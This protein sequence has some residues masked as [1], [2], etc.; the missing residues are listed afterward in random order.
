MADFD[1]IIDDSNIRVTE[2]YFRR[3]NGQKWRGIRDALYDTGA[4]SAKW[5]RRLVETG[6]RSGRLYVLS[7]RIRF[8]AQ[9]RLH[10]ASAPFEPPARM[11]G[12]LAKGVQYAVRQV[13]ELEV[14]VRLDDRSLPN[15]PKMLE[16]GTRKMKARPFVRPTSLE[17]AHRMSINLAHYGQIEAKRVKR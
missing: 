10:R 11:T 15:Y 7:G 13:H 3:L 5:M 8:L 1:L 14:G 17:W 6:T 16:T 4:Q 2:R 12:R 9:K